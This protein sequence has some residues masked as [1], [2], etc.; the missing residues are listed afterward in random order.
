MK[1]YGRYGDLIQQCEVSLSRMLN[2]ILTLDLLQWL[3][4]RSD[5]QINDL[6]TE[7]DLH[8]MTSCFHGAFATGVTW[9]QGTFNLPNSVPSPFVG[10]AYAPIVDRWDQ[11][12][13]ICRVL[14]RRFTLKTPRCF[15]DCS[16]LIRYNGVKQ[17]CLANAYFTLKLNMLEYKKRWFGIVSSTFA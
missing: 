3:Y 6:D 11:F 8:Q 15:L 4:N 16:L 10:R 13:K 14:S 17:I 2:D 5:H 1:F 7:L 9:K 12:S